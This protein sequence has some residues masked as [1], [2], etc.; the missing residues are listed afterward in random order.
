MLDAVRRIHAEWV[1]LVNEVRRVA[2]AQRLELGT[3]ETLA[4]SVWAK[5]S[6]G[7]SLS[8]EVNAALQMVLERRQPQS[9]WDTRSTQ[10]AK[11]EKLAPPETL[12]EWLV[13]HEAGRLS[14]LTNPLLQSFCKEHGLA[15]GGKK[16]DK[17][18]R[19]HDF[20]EQ[21]KSQ[22]AAEPAAEDGSA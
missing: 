18:A 12:N 13:A 17:L 6:P 22:Q 10:S 9:V 19:I 11:V 3:D 21:M 4:L 20:L 15:V 16:D 5:R 8:D 14:T 7:W 2:A 1:D